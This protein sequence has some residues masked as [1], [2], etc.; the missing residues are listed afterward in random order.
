MNKKI[1]V[2]T[3]HYENEDE[4]K[5]IFQEASIRLT[6]SFPEDDLEFEPLA[7]YNNELDKQ[8]LAI[9]AFVE[10]I[11]NEPDA[12][13]FFAGNFVDDSFCMSAMSICKMYHIAAMLDKRV[14]VEDAKKEFMN[15][16]VEE[17]KNETGN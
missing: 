11:L 3:P 13:F 10:I 8:M 4:M 7:P 6:A 1:Y 12:I 2:V 15:P 9:R 5:V 14:I 16:P 17:D